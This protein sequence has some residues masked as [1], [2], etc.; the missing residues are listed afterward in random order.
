MHIHYGLKEKN[1]VANLRFFSKHTQQSGESIGREM[2]ER[3]YESTLPRVFESKKIRVF[4]R[5]HNKVPLA[6]AAFEAWCRQV[7]T[8][9]PFPS[10]NCNSQSQGQGEYLTQFSQDSNF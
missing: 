5:H 3:T 4:C 10:S 2:D 7:D 1:P 8:H 6:R 9:S